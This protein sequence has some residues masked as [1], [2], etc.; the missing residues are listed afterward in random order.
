MKGGSPIAGYT[1]PSR[2]GDEPK[3]L[4]TNQGLKTAAHVKFAV[5]VLDMGLDLVDGIISSFGDSWTR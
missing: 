3:R 5:D 2:L 1:N 4:D